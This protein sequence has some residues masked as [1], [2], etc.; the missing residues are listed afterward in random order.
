M[1]KRIALGKSLI[2]CV[3]LI[4]VMLSLT[5]CGGELSV[6]PPSA[7]QKSEMAQKS[8]EAFITSA[9]KSPKAAARE[10]SILMESLDAYATE[11]EGPYV[12]LRDSAKELLGLYESKAAKDKI[13]AQLDVLK[14]KADALSSGVASE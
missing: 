9:K 5:A 14:Q 11:F 10:L 2:S 3:A 6:P 13:N 12:A 4:L 8:I 7:T 1:L